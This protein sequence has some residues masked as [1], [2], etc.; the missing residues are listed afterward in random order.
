VGGGVCLLQ[1]GSRLLRA[2]GG[3]NLREDMGRRKKSARLAGRYLPL[4][5]IGQL[6]LSSCYKLP[7]SRD[8]RLTRDEPNDL[9][10][11][12]TWIPDKST[13]DDMRERGGYDGSAATK[14]IL[15]ADGSAEFINMPD[16]LIETDSSSEKRLWSESGTWKKS[17][18]G[19]L[20]TVKFRSV[21]N[22]YMSLDLLNQKPPYELS[23]V[24]GD[25]DSYEFM[26]FTKEK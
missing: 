21:N 3:L 23:I 14:I 7:G 6:L 24:L 12:G 1:G 25:P 15:R 18:E 17:R 5:L 11:V 26:T 16:W 20:W 8:L 9:D 22:R 4:F 13:A 2:S 10:L 19:T